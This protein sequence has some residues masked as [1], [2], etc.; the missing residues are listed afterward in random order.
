MVPVGNAVKVI[1]CS[2]D[3][4][5]GLCLRGTSKYKENGKIDWKSVNSLISYYS[6]DV[7]EL[8][9]SRGSSSGDFYTF[10][11]IM[12]TYN[13]E[14]FGENLNFGICGQAEDRCLAETMDKGDFWLAINEQT[15]KLPI[16]VNNSNDLKSLLI[17][18]WEHNLLKE[19]DPAYDALG[20]LSESTK[21]LE[22][23]NAEIINKNFK[24]VSKAYRNHV[25]GNIADEFGKMNQKELDYW[26]PIIEKELNG[27]YTKNNE[28]IFEF[29]KNKK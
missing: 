26:K 14:L 19:N 1:T 20:T 23:L 5:Y 18:E 21:E 27:T 24:G 13:K 25:I 4:F 11:G 8:K 7:T 10:R 28:G 17:H 2:Y 9:G 29:K 15:H 12:N 6:K 22:S 3:V 16:E